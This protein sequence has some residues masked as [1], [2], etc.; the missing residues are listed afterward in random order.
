[1]K[2]QMKIEKLTEWARHESLASRICDSCGELSEQHYAVEFWPTGDHRECCGTHT[3]VSDILRGRTI[4]VETGL[5][6]RKAQP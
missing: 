2:D 4:F 5:M 3:E 1:M 6:I